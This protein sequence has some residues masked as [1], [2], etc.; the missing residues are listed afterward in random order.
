MHLPRSSLAD[1]VGRSTALFT[2]LIEAL[3]R[4]VLSADRLHGDDTP[5]PV[6]DPGR[7]KGQSKNWLLS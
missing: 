5:V 2:P 1:W 7:G 3:E 6:L 4:H